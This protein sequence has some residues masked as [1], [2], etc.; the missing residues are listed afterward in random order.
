MCPTLHFPDNWVKSLYVFVCK[1]CASEGALLPILWSGT[2][3]S[4]TAAYCIFL[5]L[6]HWSSIYVLWKAA[7]SH[8]F[9]WL[10]KFMV[11][12]KGFWVTVIAVAH[13]HPKDHKFHTSVYSALSTS[14][15]LYQSYKCL[16]DFDIYVFIGNNLKGPILIFE[17]WRYLKVTI[18]DASFG[19]LWMP[20]SLSF[21]NDP[22][23]FIDAFKVPSKSW[24]EIRWIL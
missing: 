19:R 21:L 6:A 1:F 13:C 14:H 10:A 17:A 3:L 20:K 7:I 12:I 24:A 2:S 5:R 18:C 23:C 22:V 9:I 16:T 8:Y 15:Q 11:P 4:V